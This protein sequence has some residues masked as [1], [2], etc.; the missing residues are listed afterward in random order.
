[1]S[2]PLHLISGFLGSGKTSFLKY[3]L[4]KFGTQR[5]I[6]IIQNEFSSVN[7][8]KQ[9]SALND[10]YRIL[11]V[12]NG[13]AFCVCLLGS[14]IKS[15]SAFIDDVKPD[16]LLME[17][18]GISDPIGVGQIFQSPDLKGKVFLDH[19]WSIVD[20][21]NLHKLRSFRFRFERQIQVADT[22]IIN[23]TEKVKHSIEETVH[24]IKRVNPYATVLKGN[25]CRIDLSN[26]EK[27]SV[28]A[29]LMNNKPAGS[30]NLSSFVIKSTKLITPNKLDLFIEQIKENCIRCK[31]FVNLEGGEIAQVQGVFN[32]YSFSE[33]KK[34]AGPTELILI[35]TFDSSVNFQTLYEDYC[36]G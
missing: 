35:G 16:E 19:V 1:M 9:E 30:P 3:Y 4:E 24:Q 14:F 31:G 15:L 20:G 33:V 21:R 28:F 18:S 10:N 17:A 12:N 11:E 26:M 23:K 8:D 32:D 5:R 29:P 13:S 36:I 27:K 22:I 2:V 34:N 7:I 25:Y 6:A